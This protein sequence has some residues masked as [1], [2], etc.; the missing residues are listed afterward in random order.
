MVGVER[1]RQAPPCN[2]G[3]LSSAPRPGAEVLLEDSHIQSPCL[4][5]VTLGRRLPSRYTVILKGVMLK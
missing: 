4:G 3:P 1:R 5:G 2:R